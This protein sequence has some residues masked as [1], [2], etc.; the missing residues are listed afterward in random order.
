MQG[1]IL[2]SYGHTNQAMIVSVVANIVNV[3]G[4]AISLYGW[5]GLPVLGVRGVA[6][7]SGFSMFVSCILF[8]IFIKQKK[9]VDFSFKAFFK[10][11]FT[12]Y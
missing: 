9:A 1:A 2:R 12:P 5:F 8:F 10:V 11:F 6:F 3:L 4:N 7:A